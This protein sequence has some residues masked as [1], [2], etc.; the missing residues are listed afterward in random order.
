MGNAAGT[1]A[2]FLLLDV[3]GVGLMHGIEHIDLHA[4]CV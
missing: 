4:G 2:P 1:G 3:G